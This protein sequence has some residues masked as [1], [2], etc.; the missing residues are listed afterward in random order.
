LRQ[1]DHKS[2]ANE[3]ERRQRERETRGR[4]RKIGRKE[5]SKLEP[6]VRKA[7]FKY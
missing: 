7:E 4:G 2:E 5:G 6:R 3:R 1:E